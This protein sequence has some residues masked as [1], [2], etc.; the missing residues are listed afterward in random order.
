MKNTITVNDAIK[1]TARFWSVLSAIMI[2]LF[3]F[4]EG[5]DP[6]KLTLNEWIGFIFFPIGLVLGLIISWKKEIFGG[7]ITIVSIAAFT[8]TMGFNWYIIALGFPSVLFIIHGTIV[9]DKHE[10]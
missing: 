10:V 8:I 5:F 7:V 6:T 1:T 3:L 2:L 9:K 4:G